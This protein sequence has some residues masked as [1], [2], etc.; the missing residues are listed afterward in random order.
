MIIC[1]CN[2]ITKAEIEEAILSLLDE[3]EWRLITPGL[4]YH[5][6]KKRGKCCGCFPGLINI[7][8]NTTEDYHRRIATPETDILPFILRIKKEHDCCDTVR[9]LSQKRKKRVV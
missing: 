9:K 1:S 8:I 5:T 2:I 7:I 3:D 6:L 4:V